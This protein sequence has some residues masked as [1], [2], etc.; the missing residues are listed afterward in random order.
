[1]CVC[2]ERKTRHKKI[3]KRYES[4]YKI[5]TAN[6]CACGEVTPTRIWRVLIHVPIENKMGLSEGAES[7]TWWEMIGA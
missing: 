7:P 4:G 1:V 2:R 3:G 6:L 5:L